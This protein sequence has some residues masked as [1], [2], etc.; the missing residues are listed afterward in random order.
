MAHLKEQ[1]NIMPE[2]AEDKQKENSFYVL[3]KTKKHFIS[4]FLEW[5][6]KQLK[7]VKQT[8]TAFSKSLGCVKYQADYVGYDGQ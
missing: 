1:S 6:G 2:E 3:I 5:S 8:K 7:L 4:P